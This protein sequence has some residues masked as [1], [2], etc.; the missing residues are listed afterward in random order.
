MKNRR[1]SLLPGQRR[2]N[3]PEMPKLDIPCPCCEG[4]ISYVG[5]TAFE[6]PAGIDASLLCGECV[7]VAPAKVRRSMALATLPC[8]RPCSQAAPSPA[9]VPALTRAA[10]HPCT[11]HPHSCLRPDLRQGSSAVCVADE[12]GRD[13]GLHCRGALRGRGQSG[14]GGGGRAAHLCQRDRAAHGAAVLQDQPARVPVEV[15]RPLLDS[16]RG[17]RRGRSGRQGLRRLQ[18]GIAQPRRR[19]RKGDGLRGNG[20]VRGARR[21]RDALC[22]GTGGR[23]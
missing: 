12:R 16:A 2:A 23:L 22:R 8:C 4:R 3:P 17:A 20:R 6:K 13:R 7:E 15:P 19:L 11:C 1:P 18:G 9:A 5:T 10:W 14:D 21:V